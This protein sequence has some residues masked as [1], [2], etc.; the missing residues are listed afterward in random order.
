MTTPLIPF[1]ATDMC[2]CG[3]TE[4]K[5]DPVA[6]RY[7]QATLSEALPRGCVCQVGPHVPARSY[8]RR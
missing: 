4:D 2:H 1:L 7:C 3:H 8:D 5:H 6:H